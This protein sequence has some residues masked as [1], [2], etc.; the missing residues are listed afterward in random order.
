M[1]LSGEVCGMRHRM[2]R[3]I[4][5]RMTA[6]EYSTICPHQ[7]VAVPLE[8]GL[9]AR[10]GRLHRHGIYIR[11]V[12]DGR[13][14]LRLCIARF[15]CPGCRRTTSCLPDFVLPYRFIVLGIVDAFFRAM[16]KSRRNFSFAELLRRYMRRWES[17]WSCL[18]RG[19]GCYFGP[20][21]VRDRCAGW[22]ALAE[23][24]GDIANANRVLVG[25]FAMSLL[26][27]YIIHHP[28]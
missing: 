22:T 23:R 25:K 3:L 8:C 13:E 21:R 4:R 9:C 11:S 2:Q 5:V 7:V 26:G 1:L 14:A 20:F 16:P 12:W 10:A 15:L 17:G 28:L 19:I 24:A 18:R 27:Q 6:Q